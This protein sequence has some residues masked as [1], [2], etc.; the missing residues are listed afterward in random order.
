MGE[1]VCGKGLAEVV[2]CNHFRSVGIRWRGSSHPISQCLKVLCLARRTCVYIYIYRKRDCPGDQHGC[3][4]CFICT[5]YFLAWT[6][7]Q[8]VSNMKKSIYVLWTQWCNTWYGRSYV[9]IRPIYAFMC[10]C[11][12][13]C[14][15]ACAKR[16]RSS[17]KHLLAWGMGSVGLP[18]LEALPFR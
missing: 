15:C 6:C 14:R 18:V 3:C 2:G 16:K 13:C 1:A 4:S 10:T 11:L 12:L 9:R 7:P 5:Y 17:L 8:V